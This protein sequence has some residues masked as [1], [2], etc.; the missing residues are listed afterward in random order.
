[1]S[2]P[3]PD[4]RGPVRDLLA[5]IAD[6]LDLPVPAPEKAAEAAHQSLLDDR[7]QY[8]RLAIDAILNGTAHEGIEWEANF[9]RT[10]A[11][12]RP[13]AYRTRAQFDDA[14]RA[15]AT[16]PPAADTSASATAA[17]LLAE[18]AAE[19]AAAKAQR[20]AGDE[21]PGLKDLTAGAAESAE[22][23]PGLATGTD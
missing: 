6:T 11:A 10:Q 8:V 18:A 15:A 17:E 12:K 4:V 19:Y 1:M 23:T 21:P 13:P 20:H 2:A 22:A 9:L 14:R 7:V 3:Q 16:A 5:A